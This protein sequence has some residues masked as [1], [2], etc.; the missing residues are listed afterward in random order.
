MLSVWRSKMPVSDEMLGEVLGSLAKM[1]AALQ[2]HAA[3]LNVLLVTT[4]VLLG[5]TNA[6]EAIQTL[7]AL[8]VKLL[9]S[10]STALEP[11]AIAEMIATL[12]TQK[13]G[14]A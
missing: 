9:A 13:P 4:A 6:L 14:D 12:K 3:R 11:E 5:G 7:D 1:Q 10:N 8:R 2:D